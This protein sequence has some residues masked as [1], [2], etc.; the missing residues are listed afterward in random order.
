MTAS[1]HPPCMPVLARTDRDTLLQPPFMQCQIQ[2]LSSWNMSPISLEKYS[3]IKAT[4]ALSHVMRASNDYCL[5]GWY[6][7][8][9]ESRR[10]SRE[11][12]EAQLGEGAHWAGMD[13]S[14]NS[15]IETVEQQAVHGTVEVRA[16]DAPVHGQQADISGVQARHGRW[17]GSGR[18]SASRYLE[19]RQ[20]RHCCRCEL[21]PLRF[22]ILWS[23]VTT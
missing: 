7:P 21:I 3:A 15:H 5:A 12:Q 10:I 20:L 9:L 11:K 1:L 18:R 23:L 19:W 8:S 16:V 6:L 2:C 14:V 17:S 4:S 13:E 22:A